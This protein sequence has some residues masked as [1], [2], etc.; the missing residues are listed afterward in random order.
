MLGPM[1]LL[2]RCCLQ[3][4]F[5]IWRTSFC[6]VLCAPAIKNNSMAECFG[7]SLRVT[8]PAPPMSRRRLAKRR[9]LLLPLRMPNRH[10]TA[11]VSDSCL[12]A[13]PTVTIPGK[14]GEPLEVWPRHT[15]HCRPAKQTGPTIEGE[16]VALIPDNHLL[17]RLIFE[18]IRPRT[19]SGMISEQS[20]S[21][22]ELQRTGAP[23]ASPEI[24]TPL[25][26]CAEVSVPAPLPPEIEALFTQLARRHLR[27]RATEETR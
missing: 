2:P 21:P 15:S 14:V 6:N 4:P 27:E 16:V 9:E 17:A 24:T 5:G 25:V 19:D 26:N 13:G 23:I 11:I 3:L 20:C 8:E 1:R 18:R 22:H 7:I 12:P 10:P